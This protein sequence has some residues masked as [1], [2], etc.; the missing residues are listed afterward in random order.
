MERDHLTYEEFEALQ[1]NLET[2]CIHLLCALKCLVP[3]S[4]FFGYTMKRM[5]CCVNS[6]ARTSISTYLYTIY[7][8]YLYI[9]VNIY[10]H[11]SHDSIY[12]IYVVA[13]R[14]FVRFNHINTPTGCKVACHSSIPE[15]QYPSPN[16]LV[17]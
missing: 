11:N 13:F 9:R 8:I 10:Y 12:D 5:S 16:V 7:I 17:W 15:L 3:A 2:I 4:E 6:N 1:R 14:Y